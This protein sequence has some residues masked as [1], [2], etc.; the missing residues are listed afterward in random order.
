MG[1]IFHSARDPRCR[2]DSFV[3]L[4]CHT[5][6]SLLDGANRIPELVD[7]DQGLG[8]NACAI[9]DHGNLY[10]ADRVLPRVQGGG[11]QPGHRLRGVP[12]PR[13]P[14]RQEGGPPGRRLLAPDPARQEHDRV[15]EPGQAGVDRVSGRLLLQP[16]NRPRG[17]GGPQRRAHLPERLPGRRVQRLDPAATSRRRP[18]SWPS[19]SPRSSRTT[20]TSRFRTTGS[21]CRTSAP[22]RRPGS[23]SGSACR[24]WP[25]PTPTTCAR[26]DARRP[27]RAVLH[28]HRQEARPG[29]AELSRGQDPQPV[30]RPLAGRTCTSCSRT[31]RCGPTQPGDRRRRRD[32]AST[33]RSGT[34]RSSPRR[35]KKTPE[36][37]LRELCETG[38]RERYGRDAGPKCWPGWSTSWASSAGWGS[39]ATS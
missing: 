39:P 36:D 35:G 8:M 26:T 2:A 32:R 30:L 14:A 7:A 27:R 38:L 29:P 31:S 28:Q 24:S 22:R 33:S 34:S 18:R 20:S 25:P 37:Y 1:G 19:G 3:H 6:Y 11:H 17:A 21:T 16:A 23:R 12:R 9:T 4:H 15:Q 13:Q 10:G 5:H